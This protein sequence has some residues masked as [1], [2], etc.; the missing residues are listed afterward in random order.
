MNMSSGTMSAD[1]ICGWQQCPH[2]DIIKKGDV[3]Y[4]VPKGDHPK[5]PDGTAL[6]YHAG[7]FELYLA[8]R[9]ERPTPPQPPAAPPIVNPTTS[10]AAAPV[11]SD[12]A[13]LIKQGLEALIRST[14]SGLDRE[15]VAGMIED[16]FEALKAEI[17]GAAIVRYEVTRRDGTVTDAGTQHCYFPRLLDL[18]VSGTSTYLW[19][20]PGTGKTQAAIEAAKALGLD[21]AVI[22]MSPQS[23]A[24]KLEGFID[25][26]GRYTDPDFHRLYTQGGVFVVDELDNMSA[27][28]A[29]VFNSALA[30]GVASFPCGMAVRHADFIFVGTGNTSGRGPTPQFPE[31]RKLDT[32]T[33]SRLRF[34]AWPADHKLELALA[35]AHGGGADAA[36]EKWV[37]WVQ[38][39][40]DYISRPDCG[41]GDAVHCDMRAMISGAQTIA[42]KRPWETIE[43]IAEGLVLK[44]LSADKC[45]RI[46]AACPLP[47][48]VI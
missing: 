2:G 26:Q 43:I 19:G 1:A 48:G 44:G 11:A 3:G 37:R 5:N 6:K 22:S 25:A 29:T 8:S 42:A 7:C 34:L 24:S 41:I 18:M 16:R 20:P 21:Y 45:S 15:A 38:M 9:G 14:P 31:R 23:P 40:R 39:V 36:V 28:A 30:N 10:P 32:A 4:W 12:A 17:Q 33:T 35:T 47:G 27:A 13:D 46:L